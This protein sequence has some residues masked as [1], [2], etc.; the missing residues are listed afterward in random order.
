MAAAFGLR[1]GDDGAVPSLEL[2]NNV[3]GNKDTAKL[4]GNVMTLPVNL[5]SLANPTDLAGDP[6][7][8][9]ITAGTST[10][11]YW[12]EAWTSDGTVVDVI[13]HPRV[14]LRSDVLSP[15]LTAFTS[16]GTIPATSAKGTRLTVTM[17]PARAGDRPRLLLLHHLNTL[18]RKSQLVTVT[19]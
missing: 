1:P 14:P 6:I 15:A 17:D 18:A 19:R 2:I 16:A 11:S 7:A 3:A 5:A 9:Y 4:H 8:P 12:V 13:G 10:I